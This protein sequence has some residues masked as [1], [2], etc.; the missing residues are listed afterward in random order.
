MDEDMFN[1][2]LYGVPYDS[3]VTKEVPLPTIPYS[4]PFIKST[5]HP[6]PPNM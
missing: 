3:I 6:L 2:E 4:E 1:E 5:R